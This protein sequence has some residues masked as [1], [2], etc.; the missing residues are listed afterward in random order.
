[1]KQGET[2]HMPKSVDIT[3]ADNGYI[4]RGYSGDKKMETIHETMEEAMASMQKMMGESH[5]EMKK[6]MGSN[7]S[8]RK[9]Y[10]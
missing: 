8:L 6:K 9:R 4:V 1:M 2:L 7:A 10:A 3:K 5:G